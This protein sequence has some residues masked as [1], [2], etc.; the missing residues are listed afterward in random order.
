MARRGRAAWPPMKTVL[1]V[2]LAAVTLVLVVRGLRGTTRKDPK[3]H[4]LVEQGGRIVDVRTANEYAAGHVDGAL[5]IPVDQIAD[6]MSE[7]EPKDQPILLYCASGM[8]SA[9]AARMLKEAGFDAVH[10]MKTMSAW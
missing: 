3:A 10:D 7:L 2:A 4:E 5:N 9:R 6:R 8:R 1:V